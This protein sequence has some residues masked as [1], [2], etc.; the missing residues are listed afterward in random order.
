[1]D[2][3]GAYQLLDDE[4]KK[5]S[6][7]L[8]IIQ[9]EGFAA[10]KQ[11]DPNMVIKKKDG[12]DQEIQDGWAGHVIPFDLVQ[13]DMLADDLATLAKLEGR[14]SE[15][16][17]EYETLLEELSEDDKEQ[18]FV[19][20]GKDAFVPAEGWVLECRSYPKK[21]LINICQSW[22]FWWSLL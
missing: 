3:Y 13:K 11:V 7:D 14:L 12:K 1:M 8:E 15:I 20:E 18:S 6:V 4:W 19:N 21:G 5:I 9:T 22:C 17:G 16:S 2:R 10:A